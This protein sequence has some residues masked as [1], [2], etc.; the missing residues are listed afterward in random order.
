MR[1]TR[2]SGREGEEGDAPDE[3]VELVRRRQLDEQAA[4]LLAHVKGEDLVL[5]V[6]EAVAVVEAE[7]ALVER[8]RD[9]EVAVGVIADD[10]V[11]EDERALVCDGDARESVGARGG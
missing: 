2:W 6:V 11:L 9:V 8:A 7:V 5:V 4:V 10:A 3:G 1:S